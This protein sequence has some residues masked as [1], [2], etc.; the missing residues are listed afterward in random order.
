MDA[1]ATAKLDGVALA[2]SPFV[3][4]MPHDGSA[5]TLEVSAPGYVT[6]TMMLSYD[7]DIELTVELDEAD[8]AGPDETSTT[9]ARP[10]PYPG[11]RRP[12][13]KADDPPPPPPPP[14]GKKPLNID[15]EDPYGKK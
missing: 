11:P 14:A 8:A 2:Q 9:P 13:P 10:V 15:E 4:Q 7:R 12:P 1:T 6:K 5:H 3:A